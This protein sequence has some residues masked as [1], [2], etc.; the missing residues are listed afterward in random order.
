MHQYAPTGHS[1]Q[2]LYR[3][4][5][6]L[7]LFVKLFLAQSDIKALG[8]RGSSSIKIN[9][10]KE[11]EIDYEVADMENYNAEHLRF[12]R[13]VLIKTGFIGAQVVHFRN[14]EV[15]LYFYGSGSFDISYGLL[16]TESRNDLAEMTRAIYYWKKIDEN[17]FVF[18]SE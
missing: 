17:W 11:Y 3:V 6:L 7:R 12:Y 16:Y 8:L 2:C 10:E 18:R 15:I 1:K 9:H 5:P 14:N 4:T 13:E